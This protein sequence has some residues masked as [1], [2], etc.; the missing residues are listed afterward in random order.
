[1]LK[2]RGHRHRNNHNWTL[3][4]LSGPRKG[5]VGSQRWE[6]LVT[7]NFS[8]LSEARCNCQPV[9]FQIRKPELKEK[10]QFNIRLHYL[11]TNFFPWYRL[12]LRIRETK[13]PT[14]HQLTSLHHCLA[15]VTKQPII[16]DKFWLNLSAGK[17]YTTPKK[18]AIWEKQLLL[19]CTS[20]MKYFLF[21][22]A[23]WHQNNRT[24]VTF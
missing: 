5:S 9:T 4:G 7:R 2:H 15:Q 22:L 21:I 23:H 6:K 10:S 18:P 16:I 20:H 14:T 12:K 17:P 24:L 3:E 8:S 1:M 19:R 13:S 11:F